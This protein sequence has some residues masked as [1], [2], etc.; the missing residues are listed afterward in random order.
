MDKIVILGGRSGTST[1]ARL[2]QSTV[3]KLLADTGKTEYKPLSNFIIANIGNNEAIKEYLKSLPKWDV[4]KCPELAFCLPVFNEV[5]PNCKYIWMQRPLQDRV[6]SHINLGWHRDIFKR[7]KR[8]ATLRGVVTIA[9][10]I[11]CNNAIN[12]DTAYFK[13][14]DFLTTGFIKK[15]KP[16]IINVQYEY[17]NRDFEAAMKKISIKWDINYLD[18]MD[19]WKKIKNKPQQAGRWQKSK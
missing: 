8:N 6:N 14:L 10:R 7:I 9:S 13:A 1:M 12:A 5:F 4:L 18:Y 15:H 16:D 2:L 3:D 19:E 17:F 11:D